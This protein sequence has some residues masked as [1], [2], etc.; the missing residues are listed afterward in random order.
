[1]RDVVMV[2]PARRSMTIASL[3]PEGVAAAE[4]TGRGITALLKPE[5]AAAVARAVPKR[6]EE[7]AAGRLCARHALAYFG[8]EDF[9]LRAAPDRQPLWP[10][11]LVGSITHTAGFC[12]AVVG[13]RIEFAGLGVDTEQ[14]E[15]VGAE[16]RRSI[17]IEGELHWIDSLPIADR[18]RAATLIFSAKEALYKCQY[19]GTREHMNFSDLQVALSDWGS[20][21]GSFAIAPTRPLAVFGGAPAA[22][23][24]PPRLYG[25]YR[26]HDEFV[27]AGVA[28]SARRPVG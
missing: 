19:P 23:S 5:E 25:A 6:V 24:I 22:G 21:Q 2:N 9:T 12:A 1:V 7:F 10:E 8:V 17:C 3:F 18:S 13:R 26:F 15:A 28:L 20:S 4:L 27:S 14:A 16:L 11:Q